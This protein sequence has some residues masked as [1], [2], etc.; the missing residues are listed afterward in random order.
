[1]ATQQDAQNLILAAQFQAANLINANG[2][3]MTMG[4][5][6]INQTK[7]NQYR[8]LINDLTYLTY[9][10]MDFTSDTF[11][12]I[13]DCLSNV[14]GLSGSPALNPNY[15]APNTTINVIQ[16]GGQAT[17]YTYHET[18]LV[19]AGG[20]NYYLP[21]ALDAKYVPLFLEI[22]GVSTAFTFD[23]SVVPSR[24]YGFA[25]NA[26]QTILLTVIATTSG[27]PPVTNN[28]FTYTLPFT[29]I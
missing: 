5:Q 1:M 7:I 15:Q 8:S 14:V 29:L 27:T 2:D 23:T 24:I 10:L 9:N 19:D 28:Q 12:S 22:N 18:D 17:T 4:G 20:G 16:T 26:T 11:L 25:N 13:Y 6:P 21:F 3:L